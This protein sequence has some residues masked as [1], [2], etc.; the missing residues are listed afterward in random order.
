M[1]H[2]NAGAAFHQNVEI[3]DHGIPGYDDRPKF[4]A[5]HQPLV[6]FHVESAVG[7]AWPSGRMALQAAIL[8]DGLDVLP[9]ADSGIDGFCEALGIDLELERNLGHLSI[10]WDRK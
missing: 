4:G 5:L 6:T 9:E 7:D 1:R 2:A 3:A 8:Q 10:I